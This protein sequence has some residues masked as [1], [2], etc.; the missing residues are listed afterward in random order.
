MVESIFFEKNGTWDLDHKTKDF[1]LGGTRF[2]KYIRL[3]RS[4]RHI[5]KNTILR[6]K[7]STICGHIERV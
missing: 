4:A 6:T 3:G 7:F 1:G 5:I 2:A